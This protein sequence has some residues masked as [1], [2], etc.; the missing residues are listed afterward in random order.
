MPKNLVVNRPQQLSLFLPILNPALLAKHR[1]VI[2]LEEFL[3]STS[4]RFEGNMPKLP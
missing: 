1:E 3:P 2:E 4:L